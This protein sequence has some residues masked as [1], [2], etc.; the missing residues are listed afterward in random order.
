MRKKKKLQIDMFP[1]GFIQTSVIRAQDANEDN[2]DI[3][4]G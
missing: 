3:S 2:E 1:D 4:V